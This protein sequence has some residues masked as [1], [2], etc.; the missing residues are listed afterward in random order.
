MI[1][2]ARVLAALSL[3]SLIL[4]M[5]AGMSPLGRAQFRQMNGAFARSDRYLPMAA[6]MLILAVGLGCIAAALAIADSATRA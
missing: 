5:S 3:I 4:A 1:E 6:C 2:I